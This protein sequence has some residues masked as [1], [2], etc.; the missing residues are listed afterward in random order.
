MTYD[1]PNHG[2]TWTDK[3]NYDAH[4]TK[5][6]QKTFGGNF[7]E[8]VA[9]AYG[10]IQG[11]AKTVGLKQ[12]HDFGGRWKVG[13]VEYLGSSD[14]KDRWELT[15]AGGKKSRILVLSSVNSRVVTYTKDG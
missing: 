1:D 15:P 9:M 2:A 14:N 11:L 12:S 3:A 7:H 6:K 10:A 13:T 4:D 5:A 8:E